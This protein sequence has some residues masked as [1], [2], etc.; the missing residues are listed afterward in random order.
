ME[1]EATVQI[2]DLDELTTVKEVTVAVNLTVEGSVKTRTFVSRANS[3]EQKVASS[4]FRESRG[5]A[6][7]MESE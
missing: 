4:D 7:Q 3:R 5:F 1:P 6:G 2:R